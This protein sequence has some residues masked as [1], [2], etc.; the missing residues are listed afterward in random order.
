MEQGSNHFVLH[1]FAG[2]STEHYAYEMYL[3]QP[4]KLF[5]VTQWQVLY[6]KVDRHEGGW[7][8]CL[9]GA[10]SFF[11]FSVSLLWHLAWKG[12]KK[13]GCVISV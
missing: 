8:N 4:P 2:H 5:H 7:R 9:C 11:F 10:C 12:K 3:S 6:N 1:L 13:E